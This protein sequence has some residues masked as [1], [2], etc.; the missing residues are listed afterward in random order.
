MKRR[1]G[2]QRRSGTT[3]ARR[4]WVTHW[5][6]LSLALLMP[7]ML[8][9]HAGVHASAGGG[10]AAAHHGC[11]HDHLDR[12]GLDRGGQ[13]ERAPTNAPVPPTDREQ[14]CPTCVLLAAAGKTLGLPSA[15]PGVAQAEPERFEKPAS[16]VRRAVLARLTSAHPRAPPALV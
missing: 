7:M 1:N 8:R 12:G 3:D 6:V 2:A 16:V 14:E 5:L 13:G 15:G 9:V 11:G 10:V 4:A